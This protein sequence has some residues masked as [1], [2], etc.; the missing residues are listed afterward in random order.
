MAT[1]VKFETGPSDVKL[2]RPRPHLFHPGATT[3][4]EACRS[5]PLKAP[6]QWLQVDSSHAFMP[7][8]RGTGSAS[9]ARCQ[10][11]RCTMLPSLA[12]AWD[13]LLTLAAPDGCSLSGHTLKMSLTCAA[14]RRTMATPGPVRLVGMRRNVKRDGA[15]SSCSRSCRLPGGGCLRPCDVTA[16]D[17]ISPGTWS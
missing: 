13:S 5:P 15:C 7:S 16:R 12:V 1:D 4:C 11:K 10:D 2:R 8:W 3:M 17:S 14:R 6:S 9:S